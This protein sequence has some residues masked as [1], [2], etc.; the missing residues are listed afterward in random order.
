MMVARH[1]NKSSP[2]GP[3]EQFAGGSASRSLSSC[4]RKFVFWEFVY[5]EWSGAKA[6]AIGRE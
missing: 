6:L 5:V 4:L 3:A 2:T 1:L